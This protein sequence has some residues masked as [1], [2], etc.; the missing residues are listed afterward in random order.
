MPT[1]AQHVIDEIDITKLEEW[2]QVGNVRNNSFCLV[3][4]VSKSLLDFFAFLHYELKIPAIKQDK[5][6]K[7]QSVYTFG[8]S[9]S[10]HL[11]INTS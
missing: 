10:A 2:L 7:F 1:L 5:K 6:I 8:F 11:F 4:L 9:L 3:Y